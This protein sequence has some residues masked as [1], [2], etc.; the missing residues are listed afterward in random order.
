MPSPRSICLMC[1]VLAWNSGN[2]YA[3]CEQDSRLTM[4]APR[5]GSCWSRTDW[6]ASSD[7]RL[8][9]PP[10]CSGDS[11]QPLSQGGQWQGWDLD[12]QDNPTAMG[13]LQDDVGTLQ[14]NPAWPPTWSLPK[15]PQC[16]NKWWDH[17]AVWEHWNLWSCQPMVFWPALSYMSTEIPLIKMAMAYECT[18]P[19]RWVSGLGCWAKLLCQPTS[20][21]FWTLGT[22]GGE[23]DPWAAYP[24]SSTFHTNHSLWM[25]TARS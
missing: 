25:D 22:A 5:P 20:H 9:Q 18:N 24:G 23:P 8:H 13:V 7:A 16:S 14:C 19:V 21:T 1:P 6:L 10:L 3:R 2:T 12:L 15:D 17:D 11:H 4:G